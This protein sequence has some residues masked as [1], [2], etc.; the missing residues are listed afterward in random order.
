[1]GLR[2]S[3]RFGES[4]VADRLGRRNARSRA[5]HTVDVRKYDAET[6]TGRN[7]N[8]ISNPE[9]ESG[10]IIWKKSNISSTLK[11]QALYLSRIF[12]PSWQQLSQR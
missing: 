4:S 12:I 2:A 11:I 3:F 10:A 1:M 7:I 8:I 6:G 5:N 9:L